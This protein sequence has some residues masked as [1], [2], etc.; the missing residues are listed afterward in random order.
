MSRVQKYPLLTPLSRID[1]HDQ[2]PQG[3]VEL[4][5]F[6]D[7]RPQLRE[8]LY[9]LVK[10][11]DHLALLISY[12]SGPKNQYY[13]KQY[14]LPLKA[15]SW[16]PWALEEFRKPP[17]E[18]G[19]HAGAMTS[20]DMDVDG[21]MLCVQSTTDGYALVNRSRNKQGT[22]SNYDPVDISLSWTF[23]YEL[24]F[25]ALWRSLGEKYERGEL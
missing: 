4:G 13:C 25:L 8:R 23:L 18:G 19:L 24:G 17:A 3:V 15:L 20:K 16:F 1:R 2:L 11:E 12:H 22:A 5:R 21:E 7:S 14:D 6:L 9:L 10:H